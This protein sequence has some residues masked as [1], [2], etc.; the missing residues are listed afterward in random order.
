MPGKTVLQFS[1]VIENVP[2]EWIGDIKINI[3]GKLEG[4]F[5][6]NYIPLHINSKYK[7]EQTKFNNFFSFYNIMSRF[8]G[9][10]ASSSMTFSFMN[11]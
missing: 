11:F 2:G 10:L 7:N 1:G 3:H 4:G 8:L 5:A 9:F 6:L